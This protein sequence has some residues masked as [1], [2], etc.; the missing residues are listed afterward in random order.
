MRKKVEPQWRK[1]PYGHV[2]RK[3]LW[4]PCV[5]GY[6]NC[7]RPI[8]NVDE[9]NEIVNAVR[10]EY[11]AM[12]NILKKMHRD[13]LIFIPFFVLT[14]G[15]ALCCFAAY[16]LPQVAIY[17]KIEEKALQISVK[18]K[19]ISQDFDFMERGLQVKIEKKISEFQ[20]KVN[21][22][23]FTRQLE[24]PVIIF[25]W[26]VITSM[27]PLQNET[28]TQTQT[29]PQNQHPASRPSH[30]YHHVSSCK[31]PPPAYE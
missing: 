13:E 23:T 25:E 6:D 5:E 3:L 2:P 18:Q 7:L 26:S 19:Q 30:R 27:T 21:S 17:K 12:T 31:G 14:L 24:T 15:L 9:Y 28:Q 16:R 4:D 29:Q 10:N 22:Q 8:L 1:V 20:I 11:Q